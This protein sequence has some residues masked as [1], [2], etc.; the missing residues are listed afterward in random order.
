MTYWIR[1]CVDTTPDGRPL[2][3]SAELHHDRAEGKP[4][5]IIVAAP[6]D[7]ARLEHQLGYVMDLAHEAW[8]EQLTL[9]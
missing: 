3:V 9:F 7:G 1:L 2:G 6:L 8:P 5:G 4:Q